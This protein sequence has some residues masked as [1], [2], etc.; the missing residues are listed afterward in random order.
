MQEYR[1]RPA[2]IQPR[3]CI[4]QEIELA[5]A[6]DEWDKAHRLKSGCGL[7]LLIDDIGAEPQ[8]NLATRRTL[9]RITLD[10][11]HAEGSEIGGQS[12]NDLIDRDRIALHL[13]DQQFER[14][15]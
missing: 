10:Q 3:K 14:N 6:P 8:Q 9:A 12:G 15:P 7:I 2:E 5:L 1:D 4:A 13:L 11:I